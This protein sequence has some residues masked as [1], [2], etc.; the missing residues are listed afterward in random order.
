MG[1]EPNVVKSKLEGKFLDLSVQDSQVEFEPSDFHDETDYAILFRGRTKVSKLE[2]AFARKT[3]KVVQEE[4]QHT[5]AILPK[6]DKL[7]KVI[8]ERDIAYAST[9]QKDRL[10]KT[11]RKARKDGTPSSSESRK[12]AAKKG[13]TKKWG[14]PKTPDVAIEFDE[15]VPSLLLISRQ[16]PQ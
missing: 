9:E 5:I 4:S 6:K 13:Y 1:K 15:G 3:G 14:K 12:P 7:P 2:A 8:P 11:G 10:K 16:T